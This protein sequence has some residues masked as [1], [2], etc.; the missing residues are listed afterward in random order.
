MPNHYKKDI[1]LTINA[2]GFSSTVL[3]PPNFTIPAEYDPPNPTGWKSETDLLADGDTTNKNR[4]F[5]KLYSGSFGDIRANMKF[6]YTP[7]QRR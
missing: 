7:T 2:R 5:Q 1:K 6:Q 4:L 3:A